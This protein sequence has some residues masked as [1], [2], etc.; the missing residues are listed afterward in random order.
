MKNNNG[1]PTEMP[2]DKARQLAVDL[3]GIFTGRYYMSLEPETIKSAEAIDTHTADLR[4]QL[5]A[6]QAAL[7]MAAE[8][9]IQAQAHV[10]PYSLVLSKDKPTYNLYDAM[11]DAINKL[12]GA[13]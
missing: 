11:A 5:E 2:T 13:R 3:S 12:K 6:A 1:K 8:L 7:D 10:K 4:T 9:L